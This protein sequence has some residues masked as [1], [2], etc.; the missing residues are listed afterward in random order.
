MASPSEKLAHSL[1]VLKDIQDRGQIAIR[2]GDMT[3]THRERLLKNGF[4]RDVMKGWYIP[5]RPDEA[6]GESTVWYAS[7]WGFARDYLNSRF[8]ED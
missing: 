7:F 4:I 3:R 6:P 8:N 5:A 1:S 2:A